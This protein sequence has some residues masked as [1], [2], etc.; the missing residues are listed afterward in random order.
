MRIYSMTATFGKLENQTLTFTPGLN[1]I[2]A[3]NEW[4]KSTWCAFLVAMLY[5]IDTRE[6]TTVDALADKERYAPWSGSPMSGRI[7]LC[8]NGRDITIERST[9]GRSVFGKFLA[10]ETQTGMEVPELTAANCGQV[11]LGV[12]KSVFLRAG[13]LKLTDLPVTQDES[14]RRRLNALVTTGDES[15]ASDDLAKKL[16][17]LKNNIRSN[18]AN[19]LIPK[20]E[21]QR[22]ELEIKLS[23]LS[24]LR[25]QSSRLAERRE[26]V[27][28]QL[29]KLQNHKAA[30]DYAAASSLAQRATMAKLRLDDADK[31]VA[32]LEKDCRDLPDEKTLTQ[33]LQELQRLNLQ[34]QSLQME[35]SV[36]P[37]APEKPEAPVP[38]RGLT[39]EEALQQAHADRMKYRELTQFAPKKNIWLGIAGICL[40]AAGVGAM[41]LQL[42]PG[43]VLAGA[44]AVLLVAELLRRSKEKQM[45]LQAQ[46]KAELLLERY[47]P[48]DAYR[49]ESAAEEYAA[50]LQTYESQIKAFEHKREE[51]REKME[52]VSAQI[53]QLTGGLSPVQTEQQWLKALGQRKELTDAL[54][55]KSRAEEL[56]QA[57]VSDQPVPEKPEQP[58]ELT[59]DGAETV[60]LLADAMQQQQLLAD[61]AG[62]IQ[63]K[64]AA[65][66]DEE[67]MKKQLQALQ[68]R[69]AKLEE[70]YKALE[71]ALRTLESA[72]AELQRRFAPRISQRSKELF[73]RLTGNRYDRLTLGEDFSVRAG[74]A[75][76]TTL[77]STLW[78]S[79]GTVDQLYLALRLA[80]AEE[81]TADAPLVLDDALVRFDDTRL[82]A[83]L[84]ILQQFAEN[85]QV[86]LFTCQK[87]EKILLNME[88]SE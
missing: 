68:T 31:R 46:N 40:L 75:G 33:S 84:E 14:L 35:A 87:R 44:G 55:E 21:A 11:L 12:E 77:Q 64:M 66:G 18:R 52:A 63:G 5:G 36:Q 67:A 53:Q 62:Q 13:F 51:L 45:A 38:F 57:F 17:D 28:E 81:L 25:E 37:Q 58:D 4:G 10:Y 19:G 7:E 82:Q 88:E 39:P 41:F 56:L 78:R 42:V 47:R 2:Q 15:G 16:K 74:A 8:W 70:T 73:S 34:W 65:L 43:I 3:P 85:K 83:A 9:K 20:A 23:Q 60:R 50:R 26:G 76:E 54:R 22:Q 1:V 80:V 49:W 61:Q 6:R 29:R 59:Y 79:D 30:L 71:L 27:K 24:L 86:I 48:L 72:S 32:H 69:I